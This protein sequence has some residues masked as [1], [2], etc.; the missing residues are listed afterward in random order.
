MTPPRV[1]E[2]Q[3]FFDLSHNELN[4]LIAPVVY[5]LFLPIFYESYFNLTEDLSVCS[6]TVDALVLLPALIPERLNKYCT[7]FT[8]LAS[9][10]L[11]KRL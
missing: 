5:D 11:I 3:I 9:L 2:G 8:R 1:T 7:F 6:S 10:S 4:E